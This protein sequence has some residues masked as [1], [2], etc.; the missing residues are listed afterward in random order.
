MTSA[1]DAV[2][3]S[4]KL[5]ALW[6]DAFGRQDWESL[7]SLYTDDAQLFGGTPNLFTSRQGVRRYFDAIP[8]GAA[9]TAKFGAQ[10]VVQVAPDVI[11]SAGDVA[12]RRAGALAEPRQHRI[13][14]VITNRGGEWRIASHHASPKQ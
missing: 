9:L 12:F 1:L 14:L 2:G 7:A 10:H 5:Q 3:I 4:G 11:V 13:T 6:T 8:P